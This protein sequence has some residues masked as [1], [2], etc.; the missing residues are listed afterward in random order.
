VI[1][2]WKNSITRRFAETGKNKFRGMD[3]ELA[4]K[5]LQVLDTTASLDSLSQYASFPASQVGPG[6]QGPMVDHRQWSMA[7]RLHVQGR[8][9][10]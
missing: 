2:S 5:R 1:K 6:P 4:M 7:D 10:L 8:E 9:C 3:V